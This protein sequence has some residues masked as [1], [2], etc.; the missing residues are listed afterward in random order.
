MSIEIV[1]N[2]CCGCRACEQKCAFCAISFTTDKYG[3]EYPRIDSDKCT[4]CGACESVCPIINDAVASDAA[5]QCGMAYA[6]D[7]QTK[8]NGSSGGI[9]GVLAQSVISNGGVVFGAAFDDELKLK[10]TKAVTLDELK[11]LYKSKY[12]LC[13]TSGKFSE[14]ESELKNGRTVLY[15]SSPCQISA[16]KL[17]L[18]KDYENLIVVDFVCHGVGSQTLFDRSIEYT[19]KKDAIKIKNVILRYKKSNATSYYYRYEYIKGGNNREKSDLYLSFPYYNAYCKQLA[20]RDSCY[21]CKFATRERVGDITIADFHTVKKYFPAVDRFAGVSMVIVNT[22]KGAD[23]FGLVSDK[24]SW[25]AVD[26]EIL[27]EN[28]RFS[29]E[30]VIPREQPAFRQSI[31][32]QDFDTTVKRFLKPSRDFKKMIYYKSPKFLRDLI[33]KLR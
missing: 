11:P 6:L 29:P 30:V 28:N 21:D 31:A 33:M 22:Q 9:F 18:K 15:C 4:N 8:F 1:Q 26:K 16:L 25:H 17:Y 3:F 32:E 23:L 12:L 20:C 27:Y 7:A 5:V 19:E 10:T 13:D 14:I 24:I 2:K